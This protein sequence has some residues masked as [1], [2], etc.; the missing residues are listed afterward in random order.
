MAE[1][2]DILGQAYAYRAMCYLDLA[3]LYEPK[4]NK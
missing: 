2:K 1:L 3:R 4:V